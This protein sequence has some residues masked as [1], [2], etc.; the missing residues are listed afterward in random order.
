MMTAIN[1][2]GVWRAVGRWRHHYSDPTSAGSVGTSG[3]GSFLMIVVLY[4]MYVVG[5]DRT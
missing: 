2:E 3:L 1:A 5:R 4:G